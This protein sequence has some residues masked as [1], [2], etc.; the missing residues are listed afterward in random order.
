ML[1]LPPAS[2]E[3]R[4]SSVEATRFFPTG[5]EWLYAKLYTGTVAADHA[6]R[7]IV[8]PLV[9]EMIEAE[10]AD[11]WFFIRYADPETHLR[12]RFHGDPKKLHS[13]VLPL[14]QQYSLQNP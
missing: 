4:S 10:A 5:S 11:R 13:D 1:K 3:Q 8:A 2:P 9:R 12:M 7:E 6:L 14:L